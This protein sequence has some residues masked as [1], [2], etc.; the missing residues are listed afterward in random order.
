MWR[1]VSQQPNLRGVRRVRAT[2][3]ALLG[4]ATLVG[5]AH[6]ENDGM[7]DGWAPVDLE[8][9]ND[10]AKTSLTCQLLL[11]HWFEIT[12][13]PIA[14]H[15]SLHAT[16][17]AHEATGEVAVRND[18]GDL[19][20][21]EQIQC[22]IDGTPR[23]DWVGVSIDPLRGASGKHRLACDTRACRLNRDRTPSP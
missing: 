23:R 17:I 22:G 1:L 15:G 10:A 5:C 19:M 3:I 14:P 8:I 12:L 20:R 18:V 4:V 11:A 7:P 2:A 9:A 6:A 13:G 16:L 21:L